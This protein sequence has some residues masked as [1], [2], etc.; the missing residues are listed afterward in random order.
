MALIFRLKIVEVGVASVEGDAIV[1]READSDAWNNRPGIFRKR[2]EERSGFHIDFAV[3]AS[4][5][6]NDVDAIFSQTD[7]IA[8]TGVHV[9]RFDVG[10]VVVVA[11]KISAVC[12]QQKIVLFE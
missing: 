9:P 7:D 6:G 12:R 1:E 8:Y 10:H 5:T 11:P 2:S 4:E 3:G